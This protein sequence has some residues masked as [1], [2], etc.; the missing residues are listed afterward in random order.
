MLGET[1]FAMGIGGVADRAGYNFVGG[2]LAGLDDLFPRLEGGILANL[3]RVLLPKCHELRR[4][5]EFHT[6]ARSRSKR[7]FEKKRTFFLTE[8][9]FKRRD[10]KYSTP[11]PIVPTVPGTRT[12]IS[13]LYSLFLSPLGVGLFQDLDD[14]L[15]AQSGGA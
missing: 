2:G 9:I 8:S 1:V 10:S 7:S 3:E 6:R 15:G 4:I 14:L 5:N 13:F 12:L 11:V